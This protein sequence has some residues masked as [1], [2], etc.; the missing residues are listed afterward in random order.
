MFW[1]ECSG[2]T[3]APSAAPTT[4]APTA[5]SAAPSVQPTPQP[6]KATTRSPTVFPTLVPT[7]PTPVYVVDR[8]TTSPSPPPSSPPPVH[9]IDKVDETAS[10]ASFVTPPLAVTDK[11]SS[12]VIPPAAPHD[13]KGLTILLESNKTACASPKFELRPAK[14]NFRFLCLTVVGKQQQVAFRPCQNLARQKFKL[15]G[16][17]RRSSPSLIE[18]EEIQREKQ[19][20]FQK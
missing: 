8:V 9:V 3:S 20:E 14:P 13:Q 11:F 19:R 15:K 6:T 7:P 2:A 17:A 10:P 4:G 16:R 5:P 18:R 1:W 12:P